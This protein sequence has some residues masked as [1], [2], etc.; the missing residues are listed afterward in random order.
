MIEGALL[1]AAL[2]HL[3]APMNNILAHVLVGSD[4]E[5]LIGRFGGIDGL[6]LESAAV[7]TARVEYTDFHQSSLVEA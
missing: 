1:R 7:Q 4:G 2:K 5:V 3:A 6:R